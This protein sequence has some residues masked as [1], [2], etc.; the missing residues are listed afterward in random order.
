M[1]IIPLYN[2]S[3]TYYYPQ[4]FYPSQSWQLNPYYMQQFPITESAPTVIE[5]KKKIIRLED[6]VNK[7]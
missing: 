7:L 5:K 6:D 3:G 4:Q 1:N 2:T